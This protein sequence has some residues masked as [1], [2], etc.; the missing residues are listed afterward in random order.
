MRL[1]AVLYLSV[2]PLPSASSLSPGRGSTPQRYSQEA[3]SEHGSEATSDVRRNLTL[4][5]C[6]EGEWMNL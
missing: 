2:L 5:P 4:E 6:R 3:K 1:V